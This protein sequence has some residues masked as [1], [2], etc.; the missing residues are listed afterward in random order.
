MR[1]IREAYARL[2]GRE[3][4]GDEVGYT[5]VERRF[6]QD[7]RDNVHQVLADLRE[8]GDLTPEAVSAAINGA[9]APHS[10]IS[11]GYEIVVDGI[12]VTVKNDGTRTIKGHERWARE[13]PVRTQVEEAFAGGDTLVANAHDEVIGAAAGGEK[14]RDLNGFRDAL[15]SSIAGDIARR[16]EGR[17]VGGGLRI[18]SGDTVGGQPKYTAVISPEGKITVTANENWV[19][20]SYENVQKKVAAAQTT[21]QPGG[22]PSAGPTVAVAAPRAPSRRPAA[23]TA[24]DEADEAEEAETDVITAPQEIASG[25]SG[26]SSYDPYDA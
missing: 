10:E 19:K 2:E 23:R 26:S 15:Q 13:T 22:Q 18:E 8:A 5:N 21:E 4:I 6:V 11:K 9:L 16:L 25:D 12:T 20:E 7:E 17:D 24:A 3:S 1:T 14:M